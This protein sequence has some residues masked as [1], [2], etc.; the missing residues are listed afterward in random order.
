MQLIYAVHPSRRPT[1][2]RSKLTL[3]GTKNKDVPSQ[4][5]FFVKLSFSG[6]F[7]KQ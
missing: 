3:S 5:F 2:N 7:E 6:D 1:L 4:V